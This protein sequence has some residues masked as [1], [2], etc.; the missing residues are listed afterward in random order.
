MTVQ[1]SELALAGVLGLP[2]DQRV[3]IFGKYFTFFSLFAVA[4]D[5]SNVVLKGRSGEHFEVSSRYRSNFQPS[6]FEIYSIS[7]RWPCSS[8]ASIGNP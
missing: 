8:R 3:T 7:V 4:F 1:V 2:K 6:S 5:S